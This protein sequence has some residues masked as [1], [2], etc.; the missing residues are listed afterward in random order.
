[1]LKRIFDAENPLMQ[2][3]SVACDLLLLNCFTILC[4]LPV[5]TAGAALTALSDV[6]MHIVRQEGAGVFRMYFRSFRANLKQGILVGLMFLGAAALIAV[7]YLAAAAYAPPLR[8]GVAAVALL[9]LAIAFYAFALLARYENSIRATL[10][11][12]ASLAV[13]FFPR[14]LGIVAF[15]LAM[16][17]LCLHFLRYAMPVLLMF[18]LSLPV[19][20]AALLLNDVMKKLEKN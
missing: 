20:V 13:A 4:C 8:A 17:L 5:V 7:D 2:A 16:W 1:M 10:A 9:V 3:L 6:A 19:Y 14:T 11:N 15:A 18:G 12:A